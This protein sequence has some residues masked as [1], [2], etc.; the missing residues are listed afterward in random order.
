MSMTDVVLASLELLLPSSVSVHHRLGGYLV[1]LTRVDSH[2][3]IAQETV[4][5]LA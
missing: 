3:P 4:R 5:E 2:L 1:N